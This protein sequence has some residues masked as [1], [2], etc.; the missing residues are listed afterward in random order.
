MIVK[1]R[2]PRS[3]DDISG[4]ANFAGA[5]R[6]MDS[7]ALRYFKKDGRRPPKA[8][9][10]TMHIGSPPEIVF[11]VN[12]AWIAIFIALIA[13]YDKIKQNVPQIGADIER[14]IQ[15]IQGL[16]ERG[17]RNL[18]RIVLEYLELLSHAARDDIQKAGRRLVEL[19]QVLK[20]AEYNFRRK[21]HQLMGYEDDEAPEIEIIDLDNDLE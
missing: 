6:F 19:D 18:A 5:L 4:L 7:E 8:K 20:R 3:V 2:F 11:M 21:R 14:V 15:N 16:S 13:N 12:P 1:V 10:I 17:R 9:L